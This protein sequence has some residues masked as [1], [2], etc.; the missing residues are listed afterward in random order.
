MNTGYNET[1]LEYTKKNLEILG[2]PATIVDTNIFEI[3]NS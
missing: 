2:I 3:A 1:N